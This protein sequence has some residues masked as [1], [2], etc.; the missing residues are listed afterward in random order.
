MAL[1][2][3]HAFRVFCCSSP[4]EGHLKKALAGTQKRTPSYLQRIEI[5]NERKKGQRKDT[6]KEDPVSI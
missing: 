1:F 4:Q 3:V 6:V 2:F 5:K